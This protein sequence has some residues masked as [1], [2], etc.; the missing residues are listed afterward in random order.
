MTPTLLFA[1]LPI[2]LPPPALTLL[3][4]TQSIPERHAIFENIGYLAGALS[5]LHVQVTV[6]LTSVDNLITAFKKAVSDI[7]HAIHHNDPE[8][9]QQTN[10]YETQLKNQLRLMKVRNLQILDNFD[11]AATNLR[12]RLE[13]L[14][15]MLPKPKPSPAEE[16]TKNI[17]SKRSKDQNDIPPCAES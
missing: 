5:Y 17:R 3:V 9:Q 16:L 4:D 7:R 13:S 1:L 14:T 11:T 15:S 12:I 2:I 10:Y 8:T 6:D